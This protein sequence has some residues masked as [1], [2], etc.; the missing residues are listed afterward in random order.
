MAEDR[1]QSLEIMRNASSYWLIDEPLYFYRPNPA[2]TTNAGYN[3]DY[4][5]QVCYVEEE[6]VS[7]MNDRKMLLKNWA[8]YFLIYTSS[9]L[10]GVR[11]NR[12]LNAS[13][14]HSAYARMRDQEIFGLAAEIFPISSL[15]KIDAI[16]LSFLKEGRF[17]MLD[18]SMLPW[19]LGSSAKRLI[20]AFRHANNN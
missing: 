6:V 17:V 3:L 18:L 10:L 9:A 19:R 2:S 11:Y 16:R 20:N 4:F 13:V 8:S 14:R 1:L 5:A 15:S 12:E 7:C